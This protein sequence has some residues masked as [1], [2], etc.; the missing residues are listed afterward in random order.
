MAVD[1]QLDIGNRLRVGGGEQ[2]ALRMI[3]DG[4]GTRKFDRETRNIRVVDGELLVVVFAK[5]CK[6]VIRNRANERVLLAHSSLWVSRG[7]EPKN[8]PLVT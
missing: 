3:D 2:C 8:A 6:N 7:P 1:L 5:N 4:V